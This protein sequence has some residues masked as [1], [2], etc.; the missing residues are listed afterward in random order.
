MA[1]SQRLSDQDRHVVQQA[2]GV[3]SRAAGSPEAGESST[4]N[5]EESAVSNAAGENNEP[6]H[7]SDGRTVTSVEAGG[8]GTGMLYNI[9][10][11]Y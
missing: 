4:Q 3:L 8:S 10:N 2:I 9:S 11:L 5:R 6:V 1:A 7:T